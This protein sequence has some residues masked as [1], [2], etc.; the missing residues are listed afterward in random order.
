MDLAAE[1]DRA[2]LAAEPDIRRQVRLAVAGLRVGLDRDRLRVL[3][4]RGDVSVL[5]AAFN[6][7][8]FEWRMGQVTDI[9]E[10]TMRRSARQAASALGVPVQ[11]ATPITLTGRL[12]LWN[13]AA[14]RMAARI[15]ARLITRITLET[16]QAIRAVI[17][18]ALAE[19]L[20]VREQAD[21][22]ADILMD[23]AGVTERQAIAI[24][25]Y[26]AALKTKG[27]DPA[28][29]NKLVRAMRDRAIQ[30]R[31]EVIART[32]TVAAANAGVQATWDEMRQQGILP[33]HIRRQWLTARDERTCPICKPMD[34]QVRA[35]GELFE[36]P[37]NNALIE[38]P[39]IHPQCR[40]TM[41]LNPADL[42]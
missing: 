14:V 5:L 23:V 40:C 11:K 36:S 15:A 13:P 6:W 41:T 42:E 25:N 8:V 35:F 24:M 28:R 22:I 18:R 20:A 34:G 38:F 32:E 4:L 31:A 7:P 27:M 29:I 39:P 1:I 10:R 37:A 19:G 2:A 16:Q 17:V 3:A 9:F 21:L 33:D 26:R 12:R 30:Q